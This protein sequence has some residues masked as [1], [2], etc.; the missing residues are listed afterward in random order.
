MQFTGCAV[1]H[2]LCS[3]E[4]HPF[5]VSLANATKI[6]FQIVEDGKE[7][8]NGKKAKK[9]CVIADDVK[10][11]ASPNRWLIRQMKSQRREFF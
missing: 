10:N 2:D 9:N 8:K 11:Y 7:E 3:G 5:D 6:I 4:I 1:E